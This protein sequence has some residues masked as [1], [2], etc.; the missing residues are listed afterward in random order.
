[1]ILLASTEAGKVGILIFNF[2]EGVSGSS[3]SSESLVSSSDSD[4]FDSISL[5]LGFFVLFF[6]LRD[7][8]SALKSVSKSDELSSPLLVPSSSSSSEDEK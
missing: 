8:S 4:I 7:D 3:S 2:K 1:M 5:A 6:S